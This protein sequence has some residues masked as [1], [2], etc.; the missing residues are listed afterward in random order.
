MLL[1]SR[2]PKRTNSRLLRRCKQVLLLIRPSSDLSNKLAAVA[3]LG[4][5]IEA[6]RR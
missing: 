3:V 4:V 6:L 5:R 1:Q 2:R